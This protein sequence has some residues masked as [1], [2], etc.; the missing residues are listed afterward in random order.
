[1]RAP[2]VSR[3]LLKHALSDPRL[4]LRDRVVEL[5]GDCL[6]LER[7]NRVRV[8]LRGHDDE[9]DDG[10]LASCLLQ[11]GVEAC[12][13]REGERRAI[14]TTGQKQIMAR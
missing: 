14:S 13:A 6:A 5:L 7:L 2:S 12:R 8:G 1:M 10:H 3:S 9:C 4:D 11:L